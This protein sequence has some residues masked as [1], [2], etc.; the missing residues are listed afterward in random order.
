[1]T[2][3]ASESSAHGLMMSAHYCWPRGFSWFAEVKSKS[4]CLRSERICQDHIHRSVGIKWESPNFTGSWPSLSL[5]CLSYRFF[6]HYCH[7]KIIIK[8]PIAISSINCRWQLEIWMQK[9]VIDPYFIPHKNLNWGF[10]KDLKARSET[11]NQLEENIL[12][13]L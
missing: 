7:E 9:I 1:M 4:M 11:I 3:N 8:F 13:K 2:P 10:I 5:H 12:E 6:T